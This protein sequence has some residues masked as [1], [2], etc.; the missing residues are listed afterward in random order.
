MY[1]LTLAP[2]YARFDNPDPVADSD[3]ENSGTGRRGAEPQ[4]AGRFS[5]CGSKIL[6]I[7]CQRERWALRVSDD[8]AAHVMSTFLAYNLPLTK[9]FFFFS[10]NIEADDLSLLL[11]FVNT[12][13]NTY[14]GFRGVGGMGG[15]S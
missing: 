9:L 13:S 11:S 12:I 5:L 6:Y 1:T 8:E 7:S 2:I 4:H 15:G 3:R 14:T 10:F